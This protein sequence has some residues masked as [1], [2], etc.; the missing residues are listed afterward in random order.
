MISGKSQIVRQKNIDSNS[1][2]A[3]SR[4]RDYLL[5]EFREEVITDVSVELEQ[6]NQSIAKLTYKLTAEECE[7]D[8]FNFN[9]SNLNLDLT[10]SSSS[11]SSSP[12]NLLNTSSCERSPR[13]LSSTLSTVTSSTE[14]SPFN[15]TSACNLSSNKKEKQSKQ[16]SSNKQLVS[17]N[18]V[19]ITQPKQRRLANLMRLS[20]ASSFFLAVVPEKRC[21]SLIK[22]MK[23]I[24]LTK[25]A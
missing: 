25:L 10:L 3:E 16:S 23:K 21:L 24:T 5:S 15:S 14:S 19:P 11:S 13:A 9:T 7:Y 20:Q 1:N 17:T 4:S 18:S 2:L 8:R 22:I 12:S 6:I